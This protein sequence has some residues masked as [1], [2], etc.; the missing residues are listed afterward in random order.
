M[1]SKT[2]KFSRKI[3]KNLLIELGSST[4][5]LTDENIKNDICQ[6]IHNLYFDSNGFKQFH[7]YKSDIFSV[8]AKNKKSVGFNSPDGVN[9]EILFMNMQRVLKLYQPTMNKNCTKII[10]ATEIII[11]LY[12]CINVEIARLYT[13]DK[14]YLSVLQNE[15]KL[16]NI[17][18]TLAQLETSSYDIENKL[19][20]SQ[21]EYI[22][23]LGIFAS[24][25]IAFTGGMTF[26]T[27]V[28][29][30]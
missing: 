5:L 11:D 18:E 28:L 2:D 26:S 17:H 27:S 12:D 20:N 6:Q 7:H 13:S 30:H 4:T 9:P 29:H 8:L 25:I 10:D 1:N 24:I 3:L 16:K 22:S 21:K 15:E 14:I 19:S 23:I